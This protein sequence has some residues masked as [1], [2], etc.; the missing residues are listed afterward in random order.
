MAVRSDWYGCGVGHLLMAR[1]IEF[2]QQ[3]VIGE[4]VGLV[5]LE[6]K[7]IW[8]CAKNVASALRRTRTTRPCSKF[9]NRWFQR[10]RIRLLSDR[11]F[12]S[13]R[14]GAMIGTGRTAIWFRLNLS[15]NLQFFATCFAKVA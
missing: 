5:R 7:P 6:N 10:S 11:P 3:S 1:L 15:E 8:I 2:A 9:E 12:A 14:V 13:D 4:P